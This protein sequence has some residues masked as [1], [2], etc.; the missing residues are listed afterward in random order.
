MDGVCV[1]CESGFT[2]TS[3]ERDWF[4]CKG[5]QLPTKC[6][7]CRKGGPTLAEEIS[8]PNKLQAARN[9]DEYYDKVQ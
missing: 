1:K 5:L 7:D 4:Q 9:F 6:S 8:D 3:S 2:L